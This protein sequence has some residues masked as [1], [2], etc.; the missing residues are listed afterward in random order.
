M[1]AS[2]VYVL[3]LEEDMTTTLTISKMAH[4]N[5]SSLRDLGVNF[6]EDIDRKIIDFCDDLVA[7][8]ERNTNHKEV[9]EDLQYGYE[10]D[11][12]EIENELKEANDWLEYQ[13]YIGVLYECNCYCWGRHPDDRPVFYQYHWIEDYVSLWKIQRCM[14][15][16]FDLCNH[17][18]LEGIS[19]G[20]SPTDDPVIEEPEM[21]IHLTCGS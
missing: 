2:Q 16:E 1:I 19:V 20:L 14:K 7:I 18:F 11:L 21:C 9:M 6:G 5:F 10:F 12:C 15:S 4:S 13:G 3:K 8:E 17:R